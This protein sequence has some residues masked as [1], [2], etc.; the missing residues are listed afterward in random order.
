MSETSI[1]QQ[2]IILGDCRSVLASLPKASIDVVVS[3]PPYNLGIA[4]H[5]YDDRRPR[6]EYLRWL[7]EVAH[8]LWQVLKPAG[9]VFLN[10]GSTNQDPWIMFDVAQALRE[11]FVLQNHIV[12]V[13]AIS[14][15]ADSVGH[16]KPISS[17]RY[18][19]HNHEAI[20]HFTNTGDVP[21]DRLAIGV[22]FKDKSNIKRFGHTTDRRCAGNVWYLP[23]ETVQAKAQKFDH[24][25]GFPVELPLRC[26]RLHG[27]PATVLDPF[28]GAGTTLVAAE[29]LGQPGIG[30]ELDPQYVASAITRLRVELDRPIR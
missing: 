17:R 5:N 23:Y 25:A 20:L 26:I 1:G 13:K 2:R 6:D 7:G 22:P 16:F 12:W 21:V 14:I 10:V 9:S 15:G 27:L 3:S 18:L 29:R 4:Y 30:I 24:P 8:L 19:N 11:R 28:M